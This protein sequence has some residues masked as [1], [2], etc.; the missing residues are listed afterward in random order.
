MFAPHRFASLAKKS[1]NRICS[2]S[3]GVKLVSPSGHVHV[4]CGHTLLL[5]NG[6]P[7]GHMHVGL[8]SLPQGLSSQA[9]STS[10][11]LLR[12]PDCADVILAIARSP[13][14]TLVMVSFTCLYLTPM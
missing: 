12:S 1:L 8:T 2:T 13:Q 7:L 3:F 5:E 14:M 4:G 9:S 6:S 11:A 10:N